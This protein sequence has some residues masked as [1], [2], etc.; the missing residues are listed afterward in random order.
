M[1][2][3]FEIQDELTGTNLSHL[4][5][6]NCT[7][8][9]ITKN[10]FAQTNS[11]YFTDAT[12]M[13]QLDMNFASYYFDALKDYSD[14]KVG[15]PAWEVTFDFCKKDTSLPLIYLA[16]GVNAHVNNDLGL[17][18]FDSI[19]NTTFKNDFDK[20]N[21]IIFESLEEVIKTVHLSVLYKPFMGFLIYHWRKHAWNNYLG[22]VNKTKT[23]STIEEKSASIAKEL[24]KIDS[25]RNFY[26][27]G[28]I[29]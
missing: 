24:T 22:L 21:A 26:H 3:M 1:N 9:I 29:L 15:T 12:A 4:Q 7:Y 2:H 5:Y 14:G 18:L 8:I 19:K 20:V 16:L 10:V 13:K 23:R 11:G 27:L 25:L 17:A 6:F 28:K